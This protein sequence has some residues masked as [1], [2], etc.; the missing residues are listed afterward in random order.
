MNFDFQVKTWE[1]VTVPE[2]YQN[3]VKAKIEA[4][5][6]RTSQQI[7]DLIDE[8]IKNSQNRSEEYAEI[9][10]LAETSEQLYPSDMKGERTIEIME[11][12]EVLWDNSISKS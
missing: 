4:G 12:V 9:F 10:H 5:E 7:F 1:R 3:I 11:G 8:D 6:I 2:E